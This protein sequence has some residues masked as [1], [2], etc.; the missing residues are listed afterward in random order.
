M[1]RTEAARQVIWRQDLL[2]EVT[3][4]PSEKVLIRIDNRSTIALT[5]N[6][7]FHG[8]VLALTVEDTILGKG[9]C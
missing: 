2:S 6:R 7:V 3:G 1:A 4:E 9:D 5:K 8:H